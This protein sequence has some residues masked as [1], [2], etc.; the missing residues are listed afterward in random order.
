MDKVLQY[1][2]GYLPPNS[3]L[4]SDLPLSCL[5]SAKRPMSMTLDRSVRKRNK[6]TVDVDDIPEQRLETRCVDCIRCL[7]ADMVQQA[8]SGHP[9][10]AM[11]CAPIAHILWTKVM[12]YCPSQPKWCNRDRFVLSNGH[13]CALQYVMLH[14]S[15][16]DLSIEDLMQFRQLGSRTPGHPENHATPGIEVA[17]GPLGQGIANGVGLALAQRHMAA[18]FN[19]EGFE[20]VVDHYT[21][22]I[23]GDGCLQ[24]GISAEASSLAGHLGLGRLIVLY[25]DNKITIDGATDLSFTEDVCKRYDAYGWQTMVVEDGDSD[26]RGLYTAIVAARQDTSRPTLIRVCTTIG[27]RSSKAGTAGVHGA[28]L[29]HADLAAVKTSVGLDGD[30]CF[31]VPPDVAALYA[32]RL[33]AGE[34]KYKSWHDLFCRYAAAHPSLAAEFRR[35]QT[36]ELPEGWVSALPRFKPEDKS[37][38]TRQSSQLVLNKLADYVPELVG[39]SADLTPSNLTKFK[40]A[41]DFQQATPEGRYLRF[42]VREHAMA[43]VCNGMAAYTGLIPFCATFL[44]FTGY[45]FGAIRVSALSNFGVIYLATH[46]S[47]GLGE[48]GPTHQPIESLLS[49]RAMPNLLTMRPADANEVSGAYR[50]ALERRC[51][52]TVIALSRQACMN[53]ASSSIEGV[54][55][56]AYVLQRPASAQSR[57]LDIVLV[58]SGSEVQLLVQTLPRLS[59]LRVQLVSMPCWEL[60]D[61]QT[62]EYKADVFPEGVPVLAVE[63]LAAEGWSKYAHCVIGMRS[64][65]ASGPAKDVQGHFGFTVDNVHQKARKMLAFFESR[66]VPSLLDRPDN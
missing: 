9:G 61:R 17:T 54:A 30:R 22:V 5:A 66:P 45:A 20:G 1:N 14:L 16:Y 33:A 25:D 48:D 15:G 37:L 56:G 12:S 55:L 40:G 13:A 60:F 19:R 8:N 41:L 51:T 34:E 58:G 23:C 38:A 49:F 32:K 26:L 44:T 47:I 59:D 11:G 31:S 36:G 42:G 50:V 53:L 2:F 24:E 21:Y 43:G 28:P 29:G 57:E 7:A 39:G 64:F 27:F 4:T 3:G 63:A 18:T 65:G 6:V 10:A 46:D 62:A 52:P 35:R